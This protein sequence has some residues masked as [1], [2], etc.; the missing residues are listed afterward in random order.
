MS[1][2]SLKSL[3]G[4]ETALEAIAFQRKR[5]HSRPSARSPLRMVSVSEVAERIFGGWPWM[6]AIAFSEVADRTGGWWRCRIVAIASQPQPFASQW[7]QLHRSAQVLGDMGFPIS[8]AASFLESG[9]KIIHR[10]NT[11]EVALSS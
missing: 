1:L 10:R 7:S 11:A 8:L 2:N 6:V 3:P 5:V 4:I 9:A